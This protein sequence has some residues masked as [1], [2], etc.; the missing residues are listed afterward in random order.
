VT[1]TILAVCGV[2]PADTP[3]R[4]GRSLLPLLRGEQIPWDERTLFFQWH[5]GDV[6]E[7]YN[8]C[9]ARTQ[10]YKLVNGVE[11]YDLQADPGEEHDISAEHV[12]IVKRLRKEY[13]AWFADVSAT[14]GYE[15]A[16]I[17]VGDPHANTVY[18]TRQDMRGGDASGYGLGGFWKTR[19]AREGT[20]DITIR[21][22]PEV[23]S[24][25]GKVQVGGFNAQA[26]IDESTGLAVIRGVH[27]LDGPASVRA[28]AN[29]A[30]PKNGAHYVDIA[31]S[32][33]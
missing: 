20:Y 15:P 10:Q 17:V 1:P 18:L 27:L 23:K 30:E 7:P 25:T 11:L 16:D 21:F 8:N 28:W 9:C 5:R 14:R 32:G 24:G 29:D 4:D 31:R 6:P 2:T 26:P 12:D 19:I 33:D 22:G 3:K 13:E